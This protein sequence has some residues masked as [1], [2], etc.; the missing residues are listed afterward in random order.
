[1]GKAEE[2]AKAFGY[3]TL[4]EVAA[5]KELAGMVSGIAVNIGAGAGTSALA[6]REGNLSLQIY[7]VDISPGGPLGGLENERNA[8]KD[9]G[10]KMPY[11]IL[12]NSSDAAKQWIGEPIM[13]L[14]IDDGH[15]EWEIE[16]DITSWYQ[17]V[18]KYGIV[19]FHDYGAP[20]WPD[21]KM[22]VD[23]KKLGKKILLADTL[24]AFRRTTGARYQGKS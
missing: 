13:L 5:L 20:R 21:V 15:L 9:T 11:Q 14:L 4:K 18:P 23:R 22:V 3:L 10:L 16:R 24:I 12:G 1:M 17:F 2:V 6:I 19:A 8:F 7:T